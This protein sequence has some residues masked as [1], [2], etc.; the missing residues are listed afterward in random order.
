LVD[1]VSGRVFR[2][3]FGHPEQGEPARDPRIWE[4]A[5]AV[6]GRSRA[7]DVN[8]A[9]LDLG[10]AVCKPK[11]PRCGECPL[12]RGCAWAL[13]NYW[14]SERVRLVSRVSKAS[15]RQRGAPQP[16]AMGR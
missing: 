1:G 13:K 6:V 8:W 10:A 16:S 15:A 11:R 5:R 14:P 12:A 7:K 4:L 9:V 3:L 2:R